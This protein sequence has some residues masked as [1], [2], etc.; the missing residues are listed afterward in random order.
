[1]AIRIRKVQGRIVA[2]CAAKTVPEPEDIYL[3]DAAHHA[4]T[5]KFGLDFQSE[6]FM[7]DALAD[8]ILV[9][10]MEQEERKALV[11]N[12]H[13]RTRRQFADI[14]SSCFALFE[15]IKWGVV[16]LSVPEAVHDLKIAFYGLIETLEKGE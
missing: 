6:G 2:L 8:P 14:T 13:L 5:T 4:L 7:E 11:L 12:L 15:Y 1:M 3:D 9:P 16:I 10:I